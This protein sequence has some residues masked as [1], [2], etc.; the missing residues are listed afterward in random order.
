[1]LHQQNRKKNK[2]TEF[3]KNVKI[4]QPCDLRQWEIGNYM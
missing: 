1:M 4:N 2:L 3:L